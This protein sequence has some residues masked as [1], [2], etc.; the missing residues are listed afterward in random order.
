MAPSGYPEKSPSNDAVTGTGK[1][2]LPEIKADKE[3]VY[4]MLK[5]AR[6]PVRPIS[7]SSKEAL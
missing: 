6:S 3:I 4:M 2:N 5:L 1:A 7:A